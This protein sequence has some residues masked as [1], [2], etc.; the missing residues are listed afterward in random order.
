MRGE[1]G[2]KEDKV[3]A[4]E[5]RGRGVGGGRHT[6][7]LSTKEHTTDARRISLTR[8]QRSDRDRQRERETHTQKKESERERRGERRGEK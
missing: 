4:R 8:L 7:R 6:K 1:G 2:K 3:R 5:R